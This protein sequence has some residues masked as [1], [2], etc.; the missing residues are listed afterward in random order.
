MNICLCLGLVLCV[1]L[2]L[3]LIAGMYVKWI[4][5]LI[6]RYDDNIGMIYTMAFAP[7]AVPGIILLLIGII[8][9]VI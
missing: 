3:A 6:D 4:V 8:Q 1:P 7:L 5:Y 9:K 2:V